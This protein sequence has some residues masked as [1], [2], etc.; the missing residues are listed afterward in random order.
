VYYE[1]RASG[2]TELTENTANRGDAHV[3]GFLRVTVPP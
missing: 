3:F 2:V 1:S